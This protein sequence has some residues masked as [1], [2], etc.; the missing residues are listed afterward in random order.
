MADNYYS[1][2]KS[3]VVFAPDGPKPQVLAE[4]GK[5][6]AVVVGLQPGQKIPLHP[7]NGSAVF[8]FVEGTGFALV[9]DERF[10]VKPGATVIVPEN[11]RRG[12]EATTQLVFIAVRI[13]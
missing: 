4:T 6:R 11:G 3:N 8:H 13:A 12:M 5:F 2:W 7:E 9:N 10:A 1:D